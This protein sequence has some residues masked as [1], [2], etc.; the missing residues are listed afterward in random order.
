MEAATPRKRRRWL[1]L[2]ALAALSLGA[3]LGVRQL[4]DPERLSAFLL[5]QASDATGLAFSSEQPASVGLWPDLHLELSGLQAH[6]PSPPAPV[7]Q[8]PARV[9]RVERLEVVLPWSALFEDTLVLRRLRLQAPHLDLAASRAWLAARSDDGPPAPLRLP[10]LDTPLV[11]SGGRISHPDGS[12]ADVNLTLDALRDGEPSVLRLSAIA[13]DAQMQHRQPF[14]LALGFTPRVAADG[15]HLDPLRLEL[16]D[17]VGATTWLQAGGSLL[18]DHPRRLR[19]DLTATLPS[20]PKSWPPLP[21]ATNDAAKATLQLQLGFDGTPDARGALAL[22]LTRGE[23]RVSGGL[24]LG[25]LTDW[26]AA[27]TGTPLPPI[28]GQLESPRLQFEGVE[29]RGVRL[30]LDDSAEARPDAGE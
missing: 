9:L 28:R 14:E 17:P 4:L 3:Y 27:P 26:F 13:A 19:F 16:A 21:L 18:L 6:V 1:W 30:R 15:L 24:E 25:A 29:L 7:P 8:L 10:R 11:A 20:W 22:Q 5:R 2:V 23:E 12:L